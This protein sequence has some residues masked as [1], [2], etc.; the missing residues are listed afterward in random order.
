MK[1]VW[2]TAFDDDQF[3]LGVLNGPAC[4]ECW[5]AVE[6]AERRAVAMPRQ[7]HFDT[8][9]VPAMP[10]VAPYVAPPTRGERRRYEGEAAA[11]A[12]PRHER[13][14]QPHSWPSASQ[15][16]WGQ[17]S[18]AEAAASIPPRRVHAQRAQPAARQP[19]HERRQQP[20]PWPSAHDWDQD[21]WAEAAASIP[22]RREHDQRAAR[23][24]AQHAGRQEAQPVTRQPAQHAGRQ[25]SHP[26][27][28]QEAQ[29]AAFQTAATSRHDARRMMDT[30]M[31]SLA[32]PAPDPPT[33]QA[34]PRQVPQVAAA[35]QGT[36]AAKAQLAALESKVRASDL[37]YL[38]SL[39][40]VEGILTEHLTCIIC[41]QPYLDPVEV[42]PCEHIYCRD[43]LLQYDLD[44]GCPTCRGAITGVGWAHRTM[45][46]MANDLAVIC[47]KCNQEV[48][49]GKII[50]HAASPDD[51]KPKKTTTTAAAAPAAATPPTA[52]EVAP[53]ETKK[54]KVK[55]KKKVE[56][57]A[58]AEKLNQEGN[59]LF[60]Q[61]KGSASVEKYSQAIDLCRNVAKYFGNRAQAY[62]S[63]GK[64]D[65][66]HKDALEAVKLDQGNGKFMYR[67]AKARV[68]LGEFTAA[69]E[70]IAAGLRLFPALTAEFGELRTHLQ[71]KL[72][73]AKTQRG[74][75]NLGDKPWYDGMPREKAYKWF[76]D[77]YRLRIDDC[78]AWEGDCRG[79]YGGMSPFPDFERFFRKAKKK[80]GLI[81]E[82]WEESKMAAVGKQLLR[83]ATE[84]S[85]I[86][87]E[88]GSFVPMD[89]RILAEHVEGPL[90]GGGDDWGDDDDDDDDDEWDEAA[91]DDDEWAD[92]DNEEE[93]EEE[94]G[95][96]GR[97]GDVLLRALSRDEDQEAA[98]LLA[99]L[100]AHAHPDLWTA[101]NHLTSE[102]NRV[103]RQMNR[104]DEQ[105]ALLFSLMLDIVAL[106]TMH[107]LRDV[108][109]LAHQQLVLRKLAWHVIPVQFEA[110]YAYREVFM[111][112]MNELLLAHDHSSSF[113]AEVWRV[114]LAAWDL[115]RKYQFDTGRSI[116]AD[117]MTDWENFPG[118]IIMS[119]APHLPNTPYSS[120]SCVRDIETMQ[121]SF[122]TL[123]SLSA[124][125]KIE[126]ATTMLLRTIL[127]Q[128]LRPA[129]DEAR[130]KFASEYVRGFAASS[131][132]KSRRRK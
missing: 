25:E 60:A 119:V 100:R 80:P 73:A 33:T 125:F 66:A 53:S 127:P 65:R 117:L 111:R 71:T 88:Y 68:E 128:R 24:P 6:A 41:F 81:P 132:A 92:D 63:L 34:P 19:H 129:W 39:E 109:A 12:P 98:T 21:I 16:R 17:E 85:D 37:N 14:Q 99:S 90:G 105:R 11:T 5:Q 26:G 78:Y 116:P 4:N 30:T 7:R 52:K 35:A 29:R 48:A 87:E 82:W 114:Y 47:K 57:A 115:R 64:W 15:A 107:L 126:E 123:L 28:R 86:A 36:F 95:E 9:Y 79:L 124:P 8:S 94:Q 23:Q 97:E 72:I 84:K 46:N 1:S 38:R 2:P 45:A 83:F 67:L 31:A 49:R 20:H 113:G 40:Y 110:F 13:R 130:R 103:G 61:G 106:S 43:C 96:E 32:R 101:F 62:I 50:S 74:A 112:R 3:G 54:Y 93:E 89:M 131:S 10:Y 120:L 27:P 22:P 104:S 55:S 44:Q 69:E 76:I 118:Q 75:P 122:V 108:P 59:T 56:M 42:A 121:T 18:W 51:C 102:V 70:S 91:D 77:A 58:R